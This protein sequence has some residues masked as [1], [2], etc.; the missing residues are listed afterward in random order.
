MRKAKLNST[1]SSASGRARRRRVWLAWLCCAVPLVAVAAQQPEAAARP[2]SF[3]EGRAIVNAA[4]EHRQEARRKPDC[5][6]LV[7]K[8]YGLAGFAYPYASSFDLYAGAEDFARVKTP[9]PGDLIVWPGHVGIVV[10]PAARSFYSSVR[11]GLRIEFYDAPYWRRH[12]PAR[13][14]RYMVGS[15]D[16]LAVTTAQ[17]APRTSETSAQVLTVPVIEEDAEAR[18]AEKKQ[19]AKTISESAAA[20]A[21]VAAAPPMAQ[22]PASI[23]L[24]TSQGRPT[25]E[26]IAEAVSELSNAAGN[27][28][29]GDDFFLRRLPVVIFDQ[30]RVERVEI[31]GD[32]GWAHIR[33]E[34][35][36]W[37]SDERT[38]L[39]R[40]RLKLRWELRREGSDWAAFAPLD[41]AYV[42]RDVAVPILAAQLA[43]L[44][45]KDSAASDSGA[46]VRQPAQLARLLLALLENE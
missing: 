16:T 42:P 37:V 45:Q 35:L 10:E 24:L 31:K 30:L 32:R 18:P 36:A 12:G 41:R 25:R 26:E 39:K 2:V 27:I 17:A 11:A 44:T 43:R 23:L 9:Q 21:S 40:R 14:Y 6:H 7:H 29:R 13:F 15:R 8:V 22:L 38:E 33:M 5:S 34:S 20:A 4:W 3:G 19:P 46:A 1:R 28:L